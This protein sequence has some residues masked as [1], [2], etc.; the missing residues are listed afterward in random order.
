MTE[1][2]KSPKKTDSNLYEVQCN[3]NGG[4][5]YAANVDL[6]GTSNLP[7]I[8]P[9]TSPN[10]SETTWES[11]HKLEN[12]HLN[13]QLYAG[14]EITDDELFAHKARRFKYEADNLTFSPVRRRKLSK[15]CRGE[16]QS[17]KYQYPRKPKRKQNFNCS[18]NHVELNFRT[19]SASSSESY[20]SRYLASRNRMSEKH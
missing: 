1:K 11:Y 13:M 5:N 16:E 8:A 10:L 4:L 15:W 20:L 7:I 14:P 18:R 2:K 9:D 6:L 17:M 19:E 12:K 3:Q